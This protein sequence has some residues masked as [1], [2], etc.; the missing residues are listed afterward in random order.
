MDEESGVPLCGDEVVGVGR[1]VLKCYRL[2]KRLNCPHL[3][4]PVTPCF[5]RLAPIPSPLVLVQR[6]IT[7]CL[8]R[9]GIVLA[10]SHRVIASGRHQEALHLRHSSRPVTSLYYDIPTVL[11]HDP[12]HSYVSRTLDS[13]WTALLP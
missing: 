9:P 10:L 12:R 1:E 11:R 8:L 7:A 2:D 4:L 3:G 6:V 5:L 13:F